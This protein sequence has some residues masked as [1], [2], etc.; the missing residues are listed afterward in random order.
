VQSGSTDSAPALVNV[1]PDFFL[2]AF[3][4]LGAKGRYSIEGGTLRVDNAAREGV[5]AST[6]RDGVSAAWTR[7][8]GA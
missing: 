5:N 3:W 1:S 2:S 8:S 6:K 7:R 4:L